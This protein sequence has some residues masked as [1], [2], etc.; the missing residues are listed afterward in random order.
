V[1]HV[2]E[3]GEGIGHNLVA[4]APVDVRDEARAARI[5]LKFGPVK[6]GRSHFNYQLSISNEQLLIGHA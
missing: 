6:G 4:L 5:V 2:G 3:H 1:L